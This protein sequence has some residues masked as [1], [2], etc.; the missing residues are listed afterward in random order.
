MLQ[1]SYMVTP[2]PSGINHSPGC[3]LRG[4]TAETKLCRVFSL[5][6]VDGNHLPRSC[7]ARLISAIVV[8]KASWPRASCRRGG[9]V[10]SA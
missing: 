1:L 8:N 10:Q 2:F 6:D 9:D 5:Q 7:G 3:I 4:S